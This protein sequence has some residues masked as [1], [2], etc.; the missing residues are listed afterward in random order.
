MKNKIIF[1][2]IIIMSI[3]VLSACKSIENQ[4]TSLETVQKINPIVL[5]T[6][7][8]PTHKKPTDTAIKRPT[9]IYTRLPT[10]TLTLTPTSTPTIQVQEVDTNTKF[11]AYKN[12]ITDMDN[13]DFPCW[14]GV[15]P[16]KMDR[17]Q[18]M[19]S[20]G[21]QGYKT[22]FHYNVPG[23]AFVT[24]SLNEFDNKLGFQNNIEFFLINNYFEYSV[25]SFSP[26]TI[27]E[28]LIGLDEYS[29]ENLIDNYGYPTDIWIASQ[30]NYGHP[31]YKGYEIFL[32]YNQ[33]QFIVDYQ[34]VII[35][36]DIYQICPFIP[37]GYQVDRLN[38]FTFN[39]FT[40]LME[41]D[42]LQIEI[43][44]PFLK[45]VEEINL[46][47]EGVSDSFLNEKCIEIKGS[48]FP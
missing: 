17:Y 4:T 10:R 8:P 48:L 24:V 25:I 46:T 43:Q 7:I 19:N 20:F 3:Y 28:K 47:I 21:K 39:D 23:D 2:I 36:Q 14:W 41:E 15:E 33:Q 13:C 31:N 44:K 12:V 34:G 16:G 22:T 5:E 18:L 9:V 45:T 27:G 6:S 29:P 1:F 26:L 42:I 30:Y 35:K 11:K 38:I 32:F 40:Y 37:D